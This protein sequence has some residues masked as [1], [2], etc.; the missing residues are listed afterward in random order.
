MNAEL[1]KAMRA[2]PGNEELI[3]RFRDFYLR[4]ILDRAAFYEALAQRVTGRHI[5]HTLLLHHNLT[6]ALFLPSLIEAFRSKG[7][8]VID[9]PIALADS[10]YHRIPPATF[11]GESLIYALAKEAGYGDELR[12]PA[13]DSQYEQP[14]MMKAGLLR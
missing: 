6:S 4:H 5:P 7:W 12:Y 11:A 3:E 2:N 8:R 14:K 9:S 13:E 1:I 10:V